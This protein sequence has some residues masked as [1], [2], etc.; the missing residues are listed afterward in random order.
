MKTTEQI[1]KFVDDTIDNHKKWLQDPF[2]V[3]V[4]AD[5]GTCETLRGMDN[6]KVKERSAEFY[7]TLDAFVTLRLWIIGGEHQ[8]SDN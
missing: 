1:L 3:Y 6:P 7:A 4:D 2:V 5:N 8:V